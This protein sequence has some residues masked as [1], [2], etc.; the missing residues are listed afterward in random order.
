MSSGVNCGLIP[1][2]I[3]T[4]T[5]V[6][7][8]QI[9]DHDW[10]LDGGESVVPAASA[11]HDWYNFSHVAGSSLSSFLVALFSNQAQDE[12]DQ[13]RATGPIA[14][15][16]LFVTLLLQCAASFVRQMLLRL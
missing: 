2:Y 4:S 5:S 1:E 12:L 6:S 15:L 13:S 9:I 16:A 3:P 7:G 10:G 8:C 11:L 14:D